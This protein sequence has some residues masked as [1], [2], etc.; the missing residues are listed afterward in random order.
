[1]EDVQ[2]C[3][4]KRPSCAFMGGK[5]ASPSVGFGEPGSV[6]ACPGITGGR[7]VLATGRCSRILS[8][9]EVFSCGFALVGPKMW[10][11]REQM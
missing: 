8:H 9:N 4:K 11:L 1:M 7:V 5:G 3:G 10:V 6:C 2:F